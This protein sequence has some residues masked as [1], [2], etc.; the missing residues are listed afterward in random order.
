MTPFEGV[1]WASDCNLVKGFRH[2]GQDAMG[3]MSVLRAMAC[4]STSLMITRL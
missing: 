2:M 4:S 3:C 1:A